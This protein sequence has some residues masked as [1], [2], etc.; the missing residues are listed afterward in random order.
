MQ[1]FESLEYKDEASIIIIDN[2]STS[3]SKNALEEILKNSKIDIKIIIST[4]NLYYWGAANYALNEVD[5]NMNNYPEWIIV[6]NNDI[7]FNKS[8]LLSKILSFSTKDY[9]ILAPTIL[10]SKTNKDLN[11]FM[12]KPIDFLAKIYYSIFYLNSILGL[13]IY[14]SR[15]LLK[16]I[17]SI[18]KWTKAKGRFIY[19]PHGSF[20]IFSK[21]FFRSGGYLDQNLTMYG[22][23]F[24]TAEIARNLK[25]PIYYEPDIEVVHVEHSS[26]K[27]NWFKSFHLT[28]KAYYYYLREYL[29]V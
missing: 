5:L 14:K 17:L 15:Q 24:T 26:N 4:T 6:C 27:I 3:E 29:N 16:M 8:D 10:S 28:K 1:S 2:D 20:I 11:P 21:Y 18:F 23:E 25:I 9:P 22:E 13:I 19:A 12:A 7:L